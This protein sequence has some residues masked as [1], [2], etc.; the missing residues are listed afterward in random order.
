MFFQK[1]P[2]AVLAA[3][4]LI[5]AGCASMR[6][7]GGDSQPIIIQ[8]P[9][10]SVAQGQVSQQ[11]LPPADGFPVAPGQE[12]VQTANA[13]TALSGIALTPASVA[14][15]WNASVGGMMCKVVTPQTKYGRGYRAGPLKCPA[16]FSNLNSWN[17]NGSQLMFYDTAGNLVATLASNDG[18][19]FSGRTSTGV[20]VTLSR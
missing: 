20:P 6:F 3:T 16:V 14:G 4:A 8:P 13:G 12:Q 9:I 2:L 11:D 10:S 1:M 18:A 5:T 15:V 7:G 19:Q 17:I